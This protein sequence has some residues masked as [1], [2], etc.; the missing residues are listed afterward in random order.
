MQSGPAI[1]PPVIRSPLTP[2]RPK[3]KPNHIAVA[4]RTTPHSQRIVPSSQWSDDEE[5][6]QDSLLEAERIS[7]PYLAHH[8]EEPEPCS[9]GLAH[10]LSFNVPLQSSLATLLPLAK[11]NASATEPSKNCSNKSDS[12]NAGGVKGCPLSLNISA[13]W[14]SS[15]NYGPRDGSQSGQIEPTSQFD[16]IEMACSSQS[17]FCECPNLITDPCAM[18]TVIKRSETGPPQHRSSSSEAIVQQESSSKDCQY[19]PSQSPSPLTPLP[20]SPVSEV[21]RGKMVNVGADRSLSQQSL[22]KSPGRPVPPPSPHL[23]VDLG[24]GGV[25]QH[26]PKMDFPAE[27]PTSDEDEDIQATTSAAGASP[28]TSAHSRLRISHAKLR[29]L[30]SAAVELDSDGEE[31]SSDTSIT[32]PATSQGMSMPSSAGSYL[33]LVGTLPPEVGDFLNMVGSGTSSDT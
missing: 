25:A 32:V 13:M 26:L 5:P 4:Y 31:M 12:G 19:E 33:D 8:A 22:H 1:S 21:V 17:P 2:S 10:S 24:R 20:S 30:P 15:S 7:Y 16:E 23:I 18:A 28:L 3:S 11:L 9:N 14:L 27:G 29:S 6:S